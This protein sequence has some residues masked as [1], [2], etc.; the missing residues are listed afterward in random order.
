[1]TTNLAKWAPNN[2]QIIK[3][4]LSDGRRA[5][6]LP[7]VAGYDYYW[8]RTG[9]YLG[10][11]GLFK[12]SRSRRS[13][14]FLDRILAVESRQPENPN[15]GQATTRHYLPGFLTFGK[16]GARPESSYLGSYRPRSGG[17]LRLLKT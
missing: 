9:G 16:T 7:S 10:N 15:P 3:S 13:F 4:G 5:K 11:V 2:G 17:L 6:F 1:M 12:F 14:N 8:L